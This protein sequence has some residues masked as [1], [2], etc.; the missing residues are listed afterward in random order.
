[1]IDYKAVNVEVI[2]FS[3]IGIDEVYQNLK[4][5]Y[6]TPEGT[7]PFDREFG[8][9]TDFIDEPIPIA[10]GRLIVE[11]TD[12]TRRFEPRATVDEVFFHTDVNTGKL[13]PRVVI[14]I[15]IEAE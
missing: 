5:L 12:K 15:D 9:N 10:Q 6:T 1:M 14:R 7:V 8:I 11:Y 13:V 3:A 2:N 4:V